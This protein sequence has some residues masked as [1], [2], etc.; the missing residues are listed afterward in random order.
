MEGLSVCRWTLPSERTTS[1][2]G[3]EMLIG[4]LKRA[5]RPNEEG[6]LGQHTKESL[7]DVGELGRALEEDFMIWC[8]LPRWTQA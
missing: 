7:I 2:A 8:V 6:R 1:Y 3:G 4:E 5:A